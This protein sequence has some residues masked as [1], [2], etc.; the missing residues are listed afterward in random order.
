MAMTLYELAESYNQLNEWLETAEDPE[1]IRDTLDAVEEAFDAKVEN[2]VKL[3]RSKEAE[4]EAIDAEMKR[5][6]QREERLKR[7]IEWLQTYVQT[8]MERTGKERVKSS[9]FNITLAFNPPAVN[10][11]NEAEIP[12]EFVTVK[13]MRCIDKRAILERFKQG[14]LVPGVEIVRK[15]SLKIR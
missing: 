14:E 4:I 5:L 13:E 1:V 15:K 2:I 6:K 12:E 9:L 10:V 7:D 8:E 11:L 3:I